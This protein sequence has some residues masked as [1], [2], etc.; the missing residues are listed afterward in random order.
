[1]L[2]FSIKV[3]TELAKKWAFPE[4]IFY[5]SGA[6]LPYGLEHNPLADEW[7]ELSPD[8]SIEAWVQRRYEELRNG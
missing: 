7:R 8:C 4:F 1:M 2:K 6:H 3:M 5:V